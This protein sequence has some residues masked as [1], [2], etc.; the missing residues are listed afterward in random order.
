MPSG[1]PGSQW[2]M[3]FL[4]SINHLCDLFPAIFCIL[5]L[6]T[7]SEEFVHFKKLIAFWS[8]YVKVASDQ[9]DPGPMLCFLKY[10]C[11]K[12]GVFDSKHS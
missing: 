5:L 11:R 3:P 1:K 12:N 9:G 10:F 6:L 4:E 8:I 2:P 7:F